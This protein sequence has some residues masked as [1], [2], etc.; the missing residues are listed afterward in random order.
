MRSILVRSGAL[1]GTVGLIE[2]KQGR[3]LRRLEHV[4]SHVA[5]FLDRSLVILDRGGNE[6]I[7]MLRLYMH[8]NDGDDHVLPPSS[9]PLVPFFLL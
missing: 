7:H 2:K 3:I 5:G 9:P 1:L 4:E 6:S 8:F